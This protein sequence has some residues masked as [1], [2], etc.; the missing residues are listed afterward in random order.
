MGIEISDR[1]AIEPNS[2][3]IPERPLDCGNSGSTMR[4]MTGLLAGQDVAATLIGDLSLIRRPMKRLAEPLRQMGA[5]IRLRDEEYAPIVIEE[6]VK[7]SIIYRLTISSAQVKSAIIFASMRF[8][9]TRVS[10]LVPTRDHTERLLEHLKFQEGKT[11]I[12]SFEYD[13]PADPSAAA[14][15]I[16]GVLLRK[17]AD[18]TFRNLLLNPYRVSYLRKLHQAGASIEIMNRRLVQNELVGDVRVRSSALS[19]PI[20]ILPEEVPSLIDE[21]PALSLLGTVC[22]FDVSGA[23]ELR[24]KESDRIEAMVAN[25]EAMGIRV[26]EREDGYR[27]WPGELD[28]GVMKT[29]GDHR[30]AMTFAAAG[31]E[32]D[33]PDCVKISFPEFF[34]VLEEAGL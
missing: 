19:A 30:I 28:D 27:V 12:P 17:E 34:G 15:F 7:R 22:G 11:T 3:Q 1:I 31:L 25:L 4:M 23:Y 2:F 6:G 9:G 10:E 20:T 21:I 33:D 32:I 13:V 24:F 26:E 29:Y 16:V 5:V 14:F 18:L 8:P